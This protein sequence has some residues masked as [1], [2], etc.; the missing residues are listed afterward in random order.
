M[1]TVFSIAAMLEKQISKYTGL[2]IDFML[3]IFYINV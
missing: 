2:Y 1:K 3:L